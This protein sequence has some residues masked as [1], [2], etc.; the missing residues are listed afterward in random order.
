MTKKK[1]LRSRL[2]ELHKVNLRHCFEFG[3]E[4]PLLEIYEDDIKREVNK[5]HKNEIGPH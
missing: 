2:F 1:E 3:F 5:K 4:L